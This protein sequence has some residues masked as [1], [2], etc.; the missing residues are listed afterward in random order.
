MADEPKDDVASEITSQVASIRKTVVWMV[1]A[2]SVAGGS[3]GSLG[4]LRVDPFT[5]KDGSVVKEDI[6]ELKQRI[7][8]MEG[9]L[10]EIYSIQQTM[11]YRM[12]EREDMASETTKDMAEHRRNH[13]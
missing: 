9:R 4:L 1:L 3:V 11:L 7:F 12:S 5:S 13:P 2:G 10:N 8:R 6:S